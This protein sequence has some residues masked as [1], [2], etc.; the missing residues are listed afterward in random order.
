MLGLAKDQ[1]NHPGYLPFF[2]LL[3]L[4]ILLPLWVIFF[5]KARTI[6]RIIGFILVQ[7]KQILMNSD[8]GVIGWESAME[9]YRSQ[10]NALDGEYIKRLKDAGNFKKETKPLSESVYWFIVYCVFLL[11]SLSCIVMSVMSLKDVFPTDHSLDMLVWSATVIFM[12]ML[13]CSIV[14]ALLED[15][16]RRF[17]KIKIWCIESGF[18]LVVVI[19]A[20][21][22]ML[23]YPGIFSTP[24]LYW[25]I[26]VVFWISF[27]I[28]AGATLWYFKNLVNG[29][30]SYREFEWRWETIMGIK[31]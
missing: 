11:L 13:C 9:E 22:V 26:F 2:L 6:S 21:S 8:L 30:Y 12:L 19:I 7:E 20:G 25:C 17:Q 15:G 10:K 14:L 29:R 31:P 4:L 16:T 24:F 5:E 27:I 1:T 3:P 23:I 18:F 28:C